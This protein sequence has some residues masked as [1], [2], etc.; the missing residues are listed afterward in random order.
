TEPTGSPVPGVIPE[1]VRVVH[2]AAVDDQRAASRDPGGARG[3]RRQSPQDPRGEREPRR[4]AGEDRGGRSAER[5]GVMIPSRRKRLPLEAP[6]MRVVATAGIVAIGVV[7]AAIMGS[8]DSQAWLIGLVVSAVSLTLAALLWS[9]RR[10]EGR[11]LDETPTSALTAGPPS[12]RGRQS[13]P[14]SANADD[15]MAKPGPI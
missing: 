8:Q 3:D 10:L 1:P 12:G 7:I 9:S 4:Q 5:P 6:L 15:V 14:R 13:S 2:D 11:G